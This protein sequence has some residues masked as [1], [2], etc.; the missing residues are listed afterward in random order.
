MLDEDWGVAFAKS[1]MAG[2]AEGVEISVAVLGR[3]VSSGQLT[4]REFA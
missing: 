3:G 2:Q 1:R 4:G